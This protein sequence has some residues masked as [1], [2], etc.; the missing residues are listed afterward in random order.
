LTNKNN[1][2]YSDGGGLYAL[3]L[4]HPSHGGEIIDYLF[5]QFKAASSEPVKHGACLGLG[6]AAMGTARQDI[7]E[8]LKNI[9]YKDDA[10]IGE[11]AGIAIGLVMLDTNSW[12]TIKA[13]LSYA[14]KTKDEN[15]LRG[16][17]IGISLC[18][19]GS[20]EESDTLVETLLQDKDPIMRQ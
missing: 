8:E 7:F 5:E 11:A 3:G 6:Y 4:I 12:S 14:R 9:L 15:I 2:P 18:A 10:L 19:Y 20:L 16:L 13:M 17:A 1:S